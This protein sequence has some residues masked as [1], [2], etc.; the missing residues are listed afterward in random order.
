MPAH[1]HIYV[2][3]SK[4]AF[5]GISLIYVVV[6]C[7]NKWNIHLAISQHGSTTN[8]KPIRNINLTIFFYFVHVFHSLFYSFVCFRPFVRPFVPFFIRLFMRSFTCSLIQLFVPFVLSFIHL[9]VSSSCYTC[10]HSNHP[11]TFIVQ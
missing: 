9:F 6:I 5:G 10:P 7:L 8:D 4:T 2:C 1:L 11:A 3:V